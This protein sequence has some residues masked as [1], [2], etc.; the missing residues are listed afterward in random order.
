[1]RRKYRGTDPFKR[2][3]NHPKNVERLY[4]LYYIITL[5]AWFAVVLGAVIFIIWAIKYLI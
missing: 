5:W 3:M 4:R 1:M 2:F